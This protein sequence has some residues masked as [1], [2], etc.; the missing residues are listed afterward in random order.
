MKASI[1]LF[2]LFLSQIF[3]Q[4]ITLKGIVTDSES[5]HPLVNANIFISEKKLGTISDVNG[6]FRLSGEIKITDTLCYK[7]HRLC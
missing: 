3:P 4:D 6:H 1:I 2:L 5:D 7:L